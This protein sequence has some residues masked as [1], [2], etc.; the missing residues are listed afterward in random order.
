MYSYEHVNRAIESVGKMMTQTI[1]GEQWTA[2]FDESGKLA[3][4]EV[5]AF[6]GCAGPMNAAA[7][8]SHDW[9]AFLVSNGL[10]YTSMKD[11]MH[12]RGP[13]LGW[14]DNSGK[15]DDVLR[16]L[17]QLLADSKL[18]M[19][20]TPM[21]TAEFKGRDAATRPSLRQTRLQP[22][23]IPIHWRKLQE[24]HFSAIPG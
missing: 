22:W 5:V 23:R 17:A 16:G 2:F 21:T 1:Q 9:E 24:I 14:K 10:M 4:S 12:F 3:N 7:E 18:L 13:Y 6:G 11:A 15:R 8:F 19:I 20:A